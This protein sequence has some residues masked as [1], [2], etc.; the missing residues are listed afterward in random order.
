MGQMRTANGRNVHGAARS[1]LALA[2]EV[3]GCKSKF[4]NTTLLQLYSPP[5]SPTTRL[6]VYHLP[7]HVRTLVPKVAQM[8]HVQIPASVRNF[9]KPIA[10]TSMLLPR[11]A[12]RPSSA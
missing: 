6:P 8:L 10:L 4:E 5:P 2:R 1:R 3:N 12:I 11:D 9:M 7:S